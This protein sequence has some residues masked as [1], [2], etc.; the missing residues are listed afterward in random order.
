MS[1]G[2]D[3][4]FFLKHVIFILF[5]LF[6]FSSSPEDIFFIFREREEHLSEREASTGCFPYVPRLEMEAL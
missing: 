4:F 6:K 3:F 2:P 5:L 1:E